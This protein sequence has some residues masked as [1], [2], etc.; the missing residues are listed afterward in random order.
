MH[1]KHFGYL[2]AISA[3]TLW[4][5]FP[6]YWKLMP[7]V[8]SVEV[9]CHRIVFSLI[10]LVACITLV[11]QWDSIADVLKDRNRLLLCTLAAVLISIN[12]L[13]QHIMREAN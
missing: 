9:I 5:V 7:E 6:L 4:G 1:E 8:G 3:Y 2:R 10:T 12:W 13:G 11:R